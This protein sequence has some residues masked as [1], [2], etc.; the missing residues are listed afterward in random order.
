M[1]AK[2]SVEENGCAGELDKTSVQNALTNISAV[3]QNAMFDHAFALNQNETDEHEK[4]EEMLASC[5]S[6]GPWIKK[7]DL[8]SSNAPLTLCSK[9]DPE[10]RRTLRIDRSGSTESV[11]TT[12]GVESCQSS[13]AASDTASEPSSPSR[14][15]TPQ[16]MPPVPTNHC[17]YE[18]LRADSE[19]SGL[20]P[21][22][23][24]SLVNPNSP[25][26]SVSPIQFG[27]IGESFSERDED[28]RSDS[29]LDLSPRTD[30]S[31]ESE[32]NNKEPGL[33][34]AFSRFCLPLTDE[35]AVVPKSPKLLSPKSVSNGSNFQFLLSSTT[36]CVNINQTEN[37]RLLH[38]NSNHSMVKSSQFPH[39]LNSIEKSASKTFYDEQARRDTK[40]NSDT[41]FHSQQPLPLQSAFTKADCIK[42]LCNGL[43]ASWVSSSSQKLSSTD[44]LFIQNSAHLNPKVVLIRTNYDGGGRNLYSDESSSHQSSQSSSYSARDSTPSDLC[45]ELTS[46]CTSSNCSQSGVADCSQVGSAGSGAGDD[47]ACKW[48]NCNRSADANTTATDLIDHIREC[49]VQSQPDDS[50]SYMC[51][52]VGCKV[53]ERPS[54]SRSWLERHVLLHGGSKPFRCIVEGCNQRF[55]SE[56][57]LQ[58]HVNSHFPQSRSKAGDNANA[59]L[60]RRKK[61]KHRKK[62]QFHKCKDFFDDATLEYVRHNLLQLSSIEGMFPGG[63]PSAVTFHSTVIAKR[64]DEKGRVNVLLHWSPEDMVP[65]SWVAESDMCSNFE[66]TIPVSKLPPEALQLCSLEA[67]K[68][69]GILPRPGKRKRK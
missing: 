33:D 60:L 4:R 58:R 36:N 48:L 12:S 26:G 56:V 11:V 47:G 8:Q 53:Y 43:N 64:R 45:H 42:N 10:V 20:G 29:L 67:L 35:P 57:V 51:L 21:S 19:D 69:S 22:P 37:F 50:K 61:H 39:L 44:Q 28:D 62:P 31:Y 7:N 63:P 18:C 38:H 14:P 15:V 59:K 54:C 34:D 2:G 27:R 13:S 9:T 55:S 65:D 66:K 68:T 24:K 49:H 16:P 40:T 23:A 17:P 52:W 30:N 5:L 6:S 1:A 46:D 32:E 41:L 3:L 25:E